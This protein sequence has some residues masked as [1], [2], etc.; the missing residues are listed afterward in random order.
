MENN[1]E[2]IAAK[3]LPTTEAKEVDVLCVEPQT[4]ELVRKPGASLGGG[5]EEYDAVVHMAY[6][7]GEYAILESGSRQAVIDK[8][9]GNKIP[10]VLVYG[11]IDMTNFVGV[12]STFTLDGGVSDITSLAIPASYYEIRISFS[13]GNVNIRNNGSSLGNITMTDA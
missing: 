3:D 6:M 5:A 13:D 4:G 7:N 8:L 9:A 12:P 11:A 1:K 2:F 10:K